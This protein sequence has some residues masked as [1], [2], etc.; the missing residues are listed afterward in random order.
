MEL[1]D[2]LP[3]EVLAWYAGTSGSRATKLFEDDC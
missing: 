3:P 2:L 1:G